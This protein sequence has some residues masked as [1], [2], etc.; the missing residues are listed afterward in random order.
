MNTD[1]IIRE[2]QRIPQILTK[3]AL[4]WQ[5]IVEDGANYMKSYANQCAKIFKREINLKKSRSLRQIGKTKRR[6]LRNIRH[7]N[8]RRKDLKESVRLL[9]IIQSRT[10]VMYSRVRYWR[11]DDILQEID[12]ESS[13]TAGKL[14]EVLKFLKDQYDLEWEAMEMVIRH[15]KNVASIDE[16]IMLMRIW[17]KSSRAEREDF[18]ANLAEKF[19]AIEQHRA[20]SQ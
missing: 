8:R 14:L 17:L 2:L 7:I 13:Q 5:Q 11:N 4:N 9:H 16:A 1:R 15:L 10:Q 18:S 19:Q 6:T 12:I 20:A 3:D